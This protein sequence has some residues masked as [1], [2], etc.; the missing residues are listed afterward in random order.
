MIQETWVSMLRPVVMSLLM[1]TL[2]SLHS[3]K[4]LLKESARVLVVVKFQVEVL[5]AIKR[6]VNQDD[7]AI[8]SLQIFGCN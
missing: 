3:R 7:K 4:E 2:S 5:D 8:L 1:S 6:E